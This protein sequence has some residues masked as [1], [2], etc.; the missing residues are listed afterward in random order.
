MS[1]PALRR[2]LL[3]VPGDRPERF[4]KAIASGADLVCIDLEDAVTLAGKAQARA[5]A[6]T[7]L[8]HS[9]SACVGVRI[10]AVATDEGAADLQALI[11]AEGVSDFVLLAKCDS[12]RQLRVVE[13]ALG[14][15]CPSLIALIETATALRDLDSIAGAGGR[16]SMLMLGGYD[17]CVELRAQFGWEPLLHARGRLVSAAA[18]AGLDVMDVPFIDIRDTEA[19]VAETRRVQALGFTGKAAIHPDQVRSIQAAWTPGAAEIEQ[20]RRVV[21]AAHASVNGAIALDGKL[22]DRPVVLAAQRVLALAQG[23][24]APQ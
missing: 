9:R 20:A 21:E 19:L 5:H 18:A 24:P 17:L 7:F 4:G 14:D 1:L 12:A 10:N 3:F 8:G 16:L 23:A 13:Q 22:I 15:R 11:Q 6:A 2:C